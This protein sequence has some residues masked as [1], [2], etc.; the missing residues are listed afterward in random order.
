MEGD[1]KTSLKQSGSEDMD[2]FCL[3]QD[4]DNSRDVVNTVM[5]ILTLGFCDRES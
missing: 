2:W 1:I 4:R 5:N 3:S